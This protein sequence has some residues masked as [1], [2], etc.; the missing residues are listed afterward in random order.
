VTPAAGVRSPPSGLHS[1]PKRAQRAAAAR[2]LPPPRHAMP[3]PPPPTSADSGPTRCSTK[4]RSRG[5]AS[6]KV[7]AAA[8][9][10]G[11]LGQP[12]ARTV[13][14]AGRPT[15]SAP[16]AT[17]RPAT[18]QPPRLREGPH[19]PS[20]L[21]IAEGNLRAARGSLDLDAA[22]LFCGADQLFEFSQRRTMRPQANHDP[23][24]AAVQLGPLPP[25]VPLA[26]STDS[27]MRGPPWP[28]SPR[29]SIHVRPFPA[30]HRRPCGGPTTDATRS[31][32]AWAVSTP[33]CVTRNAASATRASS[34]DSASHNQHRYPEVRCDLN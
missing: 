23:R 16:R 7:T 25:G 29:T 10:P 9:A 11:S 14:D 19:C 34:I 28:F 26:A 31:K 17:A 27:A 15:A 4:R 32:P 33:S 30:Q 18:C 22:R 8:A 3:G 21:L 2:A 5:C 6:T 20:R 13:I 24:Q 1:G 12:R